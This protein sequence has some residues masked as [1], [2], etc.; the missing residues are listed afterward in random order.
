MVGQKRHDI[1]TKIKQYADKVSDYVG[2][3]FLRNESDKETWK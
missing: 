3:V 1:E 2:L